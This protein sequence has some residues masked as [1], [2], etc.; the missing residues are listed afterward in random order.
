MLRK[1]YADIYK[2]VGILN[3][4][5]ALEICG[6]INEALNCYAVGSSI[7]CNGLVRAF[8]GSARAGQAE[9]A[10]VCDAQPSKRDWNQ[11]LGIIRND[12]T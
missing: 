8:Q 9:P 2:H 10:R 6:P 11:E 4:R 3:K 7:A 1:G 12:W 5:S